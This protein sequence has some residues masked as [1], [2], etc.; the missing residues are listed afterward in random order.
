MIGSPQFGQ[1]YASLLIGSWQALHRQSFGTGG[2]FFNSFM[3]L[4]FSGFRVI[5]G[6]AISATFREIGVSHEGQGAVWPAATF[7]ISYSTLVPQFGHRDV[8]IMG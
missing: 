8:E 5:G 7:S 1:E 3:V 4:G 6:A 2:A